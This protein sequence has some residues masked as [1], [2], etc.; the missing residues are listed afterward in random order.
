MQFRSCKLCQKPFR[1]DDDFPN[2]QP[3]PDGQGKYK[4]FQE[5]P[6]PDFCD[7]CDLKLRL[8]CTAHERRTMIRIAQAPITF[9]E[10]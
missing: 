10:C 1:V 9:E 3:A 5:L 8:L 7:D 4:G 6:H 2:L